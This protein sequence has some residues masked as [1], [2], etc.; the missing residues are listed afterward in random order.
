MPPGSYS[1]LGSAH[2]RLLPLEQWGILAMEQV[3]AQLP[4]CPPR[5]SASAMSRSRLRAAPSR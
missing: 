5:D 1:T 4:V 3:L 2:D